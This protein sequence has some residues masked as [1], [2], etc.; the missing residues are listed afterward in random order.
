MLI[1]GID[2]A[3]RGPVIGDMF[4]ALIVIE[5]EREGYLYSIGVKDSK[6]LSPSKRV[7]LFS[8][9]IELSELVVVKRCPPELIDR[10]NLNQLF[11][12]AATKLTLTAEKKLKKSID[13]LYID[14]TGSR[15]KVINY[16]RSHG[17]KGNIIAEHNADVKYVVVS[18]A[19]II[20]KYLRDQ[21][22]DY[23]KNIYGDFGSGYP[24][25]PKTI[26]W[27]SNWINHHKRLP[28][29]VRK[30]WLTIRKLMTKNLFDYLKG[31]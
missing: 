23:L 27:L 16:I 11:I 1:A 24:S 2:E 29:I 19:S 6:A 21:Y 8:K 25:D 18:A 4:I 28:P 3:G 31:N 22:I 15:D 7:K 30:T 14:V 13:T 12:K 26:K 17:F 10:E 5:K 9:I 20:A